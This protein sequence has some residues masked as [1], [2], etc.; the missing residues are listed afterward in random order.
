MSRISWMRGGLPRMPSTWCECVFLHEGAPA[1]QHDD[2]GLR[3]FIF[4]NGGDF[5][6]VHVR[7]AQVSDD[8]VKGFAGCLRPMWNARQ[9]ALPPSAVSTSWPSCRSISKINS[10]TV[11]SSSMHRMRKGP[12]GVGFFHVGTARRNLRAPPGRRVAWWCPC[13]VRFRF[14]SGLR[15]VP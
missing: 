9:S 3:I 14:Q 4:Q 15:A 11:G 13:R 2:G 5:P 8:H 12:S 6:P 7:H 10:R 1:G